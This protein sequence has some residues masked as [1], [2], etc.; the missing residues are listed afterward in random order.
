M[1]THTPVLILEEVERHFGGPDTGVGPV[2]LTVRSGE[3]LGLRG[4]NGAGK[5]T[6]LKLMGGVLTPQSGSCRRCVELEGR[7]GYVPQEIA[8]YDTLT[9]LENLRFWGRVYGL[10]GKAIRPRSQWLLERLEL[11]HKAHAPVGTYSGGMR[12]RLHLATALMRTP[13]LL[14]LDEPTVGADPRSAQLILDLLRHLRT[15]DCATVFISHQAGEL[16]QVCD[17]ILT[18]ERGRLVVSGGEGDGG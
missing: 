7:V 2:S 3:I 6:L 13:R 18:L 15:L 11:T 16:E 17:R 5:S 1:C 8:L 4:S 14:L 9:G 12:R 10:P